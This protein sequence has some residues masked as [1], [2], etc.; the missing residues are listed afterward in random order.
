MSESGKN[1]ADKKPQNLERVIESASPCPPKTP[2]S[3]AP[4][5]K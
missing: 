3:P 1:I 5:K 4:P 2:P